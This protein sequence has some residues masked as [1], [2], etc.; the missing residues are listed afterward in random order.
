MGID[1]DAD[2]LDDS[3]SR[4]VH[5]PS[6]GEFVLRGVALSTLIGTVIFL[7]YMNK[8][9]MRRSRITNENYLKLPNEV[10]QYDANTDG[11]L[12]TSE[13]GAFIRD[14]EFKRK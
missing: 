6:L 5:S 13:L 4:K 3:T 14:Y 1:E 9:D 2:L 11:Y 8:E 12:D 7:V 10:R